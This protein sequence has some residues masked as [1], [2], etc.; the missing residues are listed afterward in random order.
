M[1]IATI[2]ERKQIN[3]GPS[4]EEALNGSQNAYEF[5]YNATLPI[6]RNELWKMGCSDQED[7]LQETYIQIF[8]KLHTLK[9]YRAFIGWGLRICHNCAFNK[10]RVNDRIEEIEV[11]Y[12]AISDE[13]N[14][15]MD[16]ILTDSRS[17]QISM[18]YYMQENNVQEIMQSILNELSPMKKSCL[19]WPDCRIQKLYVGLSLRISLQR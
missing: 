7:I 17:V 19:L 15:G 11:N 8:T 16:Q 13:E 9:D 12:Q 4:I 2:A 18:D 14:V 1:S 5:I 10:I 3:F 6:F